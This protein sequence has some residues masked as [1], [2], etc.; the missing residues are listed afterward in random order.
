MSEVMGNTREV[1]VLFVEINEAERYFLDKFID[2]GILPNFA[3][4]K[5]EGAF[6]VTKVP[7]WEDNGP[8]AW[9]DIMPWVIWPT[10]YTGIPAKEHGILAFGQDTAPLQGKCLW[11]VL[12]AKG[13]SVGVFG[14]L[15]SY[16]PRDH[17]HTRFYVPE[18]LADDA[19]CI[20]AEVRPLQ[21]FCVASSRNYS[22]DFVSQAVE[23]LKQLAQS[24]KCGVSAKTI[25]RVLLQIPK[26]KL[27]GKQTEA[28]RAML[29]S[30]LTFD[31]FKHLYAKHRPRYASM[32]MNHVAYMQ[33]RYWRAAEP[34]RFPEELSETDARFFA[35]P[36]ERDAYEAKL[37][38]RIKSAFIYTDQQ[39]GELFELIGDDTIVVVGT[40]LGQVPVDP[41]RDIHN[42]VVRLVREYAFFDAAGLT[43]YRVLHQMNPDLTITLT[44]DAAAENA[45]QIVAG[46]YVN[47][48]KPLFTIDRRANQLF[49]EF[50]MPTGL[51]GRT[52]GVYIRHTAN[53]ALKFL[54][55]DHVSQHDSNDQSTAQ[56]RDDGW[57]L[58]WSRGATV[59]AL[60]EQVAVT[61]VAPALLG[62]YGFPPEAWQTLDSPAFSVTPR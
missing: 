38:D 20:P 53:P 15:L 24:P 48:G 19:A 58:A 11:D 39:L 18:N 16:P 49:C 21:E 41:V 28:E 27:L 61:E 9:R 17:G 14:S 44:D 59:A 3:R 10:I 4:M 60:R 37:A 56:H 29:L 2:A 23:G 32:H 50:N 8:R 52:N 62:L 57:L 1:S 45:E 43:D 51:Y 33:H 35:T 40:A 30:Y 31:A 36:A 5:R 42:P 25:A 55:K 47:E 46:F 7:G 34:S 54:F 22:E 12:D 26:E 6:V 13:L